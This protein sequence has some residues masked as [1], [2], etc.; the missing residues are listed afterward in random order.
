MHGPWFSRVNM[1]GSSDGTPTGS[2]ERTPGDGLIETFDGMFQMSH[3][4]TTRT[5]PL[6]YYVP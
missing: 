3:V 4:Y 2:H 6:V 5:C 1:Y